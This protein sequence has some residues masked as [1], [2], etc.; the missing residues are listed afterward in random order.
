M[1]EICAD[2]YVLRD[3]EQWNELFNNLPQGSNI[4]GLTKDNVKNGILVNQVPGDNYYIVT[5][6]KEIN[7]IDENFIKRYFIKTKDQL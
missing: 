6:G 3:V 2:K 4:N 1:D 7:R 5:I